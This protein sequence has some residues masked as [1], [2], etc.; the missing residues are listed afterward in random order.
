MAYAIPGWPWRKPAVPPARPAERHRGVLP[1]QVLRHGCENPPA[2]QL[3]NGAWQW[4]V[5]RSPMT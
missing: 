4:P 2:I 5:W 1:D 3:T